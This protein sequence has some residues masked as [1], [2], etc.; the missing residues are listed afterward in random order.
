MPT[1]YVFPVWE[2]ILRTNRWSSYGLTP[3]ANHR[4]FFHGTYWE[5]GPSPLP[6]SSA[7]YGYATLT[8]HLSFGHMTWYHWKGF[9][10][11]STNNA[12]TIHHGHW[13]RWQDPFPGSTH[14][15]KWE[16]AVHAP[17]YTG[18]KHILTATYHSTPTTTKG[19]SQVWC[20][21]CVTSLICEDTKKQK[22]LDQP[23]EVF[24]A[25][26]YPV[27]T[28]KRTFSSTA[29]SREKDTKEDPVKSMFLYTLCQR[30]E[31]EAEESMCR[32]EDHL[33]VHPTH[34]NGH[35]CTNIHTRP[36]STLSLW[37]TFTPLFS[38]HLHFD[39]HTNTF[40]FM[41]P[42]HN[43]LSMLLSVVFSYSADEGLRCRNVL[44]KNLQ[45][46]HYHTQKVVHAPIGTICPTPFMQEEALA[47]A[48]S[49]WV[50]NAQT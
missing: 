20:I 11:A 27:R 17:W 14:H 36:S 5:E 49:D 9:M 22:E 34:W 41:S 45:L 46:L 37:S 13:G 26:G 18:N 19:C 29:R 2:P 47:T 38:C 39:P 43:Y 35:T 40:L 42:S 15:L 6:R 32:C 8:T 48:L 28:V 44:N 33:Y 10:N 1:L 30:S 50:T 21:A 25:N 24:I 16:S 3:F 31:R 12:H 23:E 4:Q 7:A